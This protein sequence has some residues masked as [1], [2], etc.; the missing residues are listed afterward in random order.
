[1]ASKQLGTRIKKWLEED[2]FQVLLSTP[3]GLEFQITVSDAYG[4]GMAFVVLKLE[5]KNAV[6][7]NTNMAFPD[8]TK[9]VKKLDNDTKNKLSQS[10][11]RSLLTMVQDHHI[12]PNLESISLIERVYVENIT[13]QKFYESL[14]KIR[15]TVLYLLSVLR[16]HFAQS[17]TSQ[18]STPSH[19]MY[20]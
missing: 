12:K 20:K 19:D 8:V 10:I 3:K 13:R 16:G 5:K 14:I 1:L 15:N 9:I 17:K 18:P 7:L 4:I 6:V 2:G 11:H